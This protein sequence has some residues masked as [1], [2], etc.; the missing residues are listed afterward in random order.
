[1]SYNFDNL[2]IRAS[3]LYKI[4]GTPKNAAKTGEQ[5]TETAK[6]YIQEL[7]KEKV[8]DYSSFFTSKYT[9]KGTYVEEESIQL[10]NDVFFTNHKKNTVRIENDFITGECDINAP[11]EV[12]DIKSSWSKD[13]FP[14]TVTEAKKAIKKSGYDW[15]GVGYMWLYDKPLFSVAY[16]LVQTPDFLLEY[17]NNIKAHLV[18]G[19]PPE[20]RVTKIGY[21]RDTKKEEAIK[22][23]VEY[24][25]QYANWY[26]NEI[27]NK[28]L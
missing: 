15:Q 1:M 28:N 24:C 4:M 7:V 18:D 19:I 22:Q 9:E 17:E 27:K 14:A 6:S 21:D 23:K 3:Q 5:L 13:T 10:Y 20:Y 16:C 26:Y 11:N 25:R 12:I 2:K 8:F